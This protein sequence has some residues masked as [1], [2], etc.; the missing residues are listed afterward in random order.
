[1]KNGSHLLLSA[2][3]S[4]QDPIWIYDVFDYDWYNGWALI[5]NPDTANRGKSADNPY[6]L[7]EPRVRSMNASLDGIFIFPASAGGS[8]ILDDNGNATPFINGRSLQQ[9][10]MFDSQWWLQ[11]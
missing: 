10:R 6:Y 1:M 8:Y 9:L 7:P 3:N 5:D 4:K 2:E 11:Y